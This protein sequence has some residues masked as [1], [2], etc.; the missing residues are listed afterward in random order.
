MSFT[1]ELFP[2]SEIAKLLT[3]CRRLLRAW[4][5]GVH[6]GYVIH[7]IAQQALLLACMPG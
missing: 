5:S 2:E 3:E 4:R 1:L 6:R 7:R